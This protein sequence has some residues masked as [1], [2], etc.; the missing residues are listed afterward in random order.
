LGNKEIKIK[1]MIT[2]ENLKE[3]KTVIIE[4]I[5]ELGCEV[6]IKS[7]MEIMLMEVEFGYKWSVEELVDTVFNQNFR[8]RAKRSGHKLAEFAG[9]NENRTFNQLTKEYQYN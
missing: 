5:I 6:N 7:F 8:D 2:I 9:N 4:R 1:I 3:N